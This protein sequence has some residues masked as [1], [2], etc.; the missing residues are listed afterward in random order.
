MSFNDPISNMLT[1]IRNGMR[2]KQEKVDVPLSKIVVSIADIMKRE[3][4]IDNYRV[5]KDTKQGI[6]RVYLRYVNKRSVIIN[7][8]RVSRPGL[9]IYSDVK[10]I[11]RV[12]RGKGMALL[13]TSKGVMTDTDAREQKIGGEVLCYIW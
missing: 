4:Y 12:L 13:T 11:P 7:L 2:A 1:L 3:G 6:L 10:R 8:K 9:R 5:I